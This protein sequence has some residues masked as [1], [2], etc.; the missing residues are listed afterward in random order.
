[1]K[2]AIGAL[3]TDPRPS[4]SK[5]LSVPDVEAEVRRLRLDQWRIVYSITES[6]RAI[7]VLAVRKRPPY[8][9][10]DL[11]N[12]IAQVVPPQEYER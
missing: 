7:D 9:Y 11:Q 8:D 5:G 10:G 4:D 6:E 12:L 2:R 1:M 3:A